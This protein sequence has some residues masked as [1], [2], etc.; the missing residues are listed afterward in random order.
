MELGGF[1]FV[2]T[3]RA[4]KAPQPDT[5]LLLVDSSSS[6]H[7][8]DDTIIP[9]MEKLM[10]NVEMLETP[11]KISTASNS[12]LLGTTTGVL[13][14]T[15]VDKDGRQHNVQIPGVTVS[16]MGRHLFSSKKAVEKDM[17]EVVD[18]DLPRLQQG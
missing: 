7:Y 13:P 1:S 14:G 18:S 5:L 11:R 17:S 12:T 8:F 4:N 2:V 3:L 6:N 15:V 16:G 10:C 9:G